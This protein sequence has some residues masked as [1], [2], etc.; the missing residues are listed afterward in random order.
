MSALHLCEAWKDCAH[1]EAGG[2][3]AVD[4]GKQRVG[5]A[6]Y[7]FGAIVALDERGN[8]FIAVGCAWRMKQFLSHAELRAPGKKR[9]KTGG[10]D[11]RRNH[12][13][14]AVGHR[15]KAAVNQN[16]SLALGIVGTDELIA[17]ADGVAEI[18][19]P[20]FFGDEG[21]R[22]GFDEA[23]LDELGAKNT[24]QARRRIINGVF[25]GTG[26]AVFFKGESGG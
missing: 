17:E 26:A 13:H 20:G 19:G 6:V 9:G 3:A 21:I 5:E 8:A 15:N 7:H 18:G 1:A 16:V 23:V 10:Q 14:Q 2:F 11:F 4:A 24:A 25:D 22:P 12:E